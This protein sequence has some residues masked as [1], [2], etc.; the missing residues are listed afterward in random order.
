MISKGETKYFNNMKSEDRQTPRAGV[1]EKNCSILALGYKDNAAH[2]IILLQ[3][4]NY[5]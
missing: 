1:A 3:I 4:Y 5:S 2:H